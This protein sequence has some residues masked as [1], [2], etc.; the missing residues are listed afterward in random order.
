MRS[1]FKSPAKSFKLDFLTYDFSCVK[2]RTVAPHSLSLRFI[3]LFGLYL[4]IRS[5]LSFPLASHQ[6]ARPSVTEVEAPESA[7]L[8][9]LPPWAPGTRPA[10]KAPASSG[11]FLA[12]SLTLPPLSSGYGWTESSGTYGV[13]LPWLAVHP[14]QTQWEKNDVR[15]QIDVAK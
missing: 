4:P 3:V 1:I 2:E 13:P 10:H 15:V 6:Q 5:I 8:V 9:C 12:C 11:A 7:S 14:T